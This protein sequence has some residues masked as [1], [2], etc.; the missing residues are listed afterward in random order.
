MI[1]PQSDPATSAVDPFE[2]LPDLLPGHGH[3]IV[4]GLDPGTRVLGYGAVVERRDGLRL[5]AAGTL[6][7]PGGASVPQR[8]AFLRGRLDQLLGRLQPTEVVVETAFANRNIRSAL[9]IGE[10]RGVCMACAAAIGSDVVEMP[11][12][13]AKK[14]LVGNGGA[15]KAQVARMVEA[16]LGLHEELPLDATDA[17]SLAV[18]HVHLRQRRDLLR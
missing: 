7:A 16:T 18:A 14:A 6:V 13:S 10:G 4:L 3:S 11:P 9:R 2:H 12:A 1:E 8:L 17:L 15:D 5:L